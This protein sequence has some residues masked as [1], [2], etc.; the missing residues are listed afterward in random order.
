MRSISAVSLLGDWGEQSITAR[1]FLMK[2]TSQK[3]T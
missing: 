2:V 1:K 3:G